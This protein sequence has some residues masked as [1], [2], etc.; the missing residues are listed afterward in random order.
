MVYDKL[1][2]LEKVRETSV[3]LWYYFYEKRFLEALAT[4]SRL[5][6]STL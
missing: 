4:W 6:G 3:A 2:P 1:K 5:S